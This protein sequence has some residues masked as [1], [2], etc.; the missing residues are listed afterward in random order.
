MNLE[1][2][3]PKERAAYVF[4]N[5]KLVSTEMLSGA[6]TAVFEVGNARIRVRYPRD[7]WEETQFETLP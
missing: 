4:R 6:M 7:E 1:S 3:P 2:L 5:G